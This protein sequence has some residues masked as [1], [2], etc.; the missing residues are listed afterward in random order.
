MRGVGVRAQAG[1]IGLVR[2]GEDER[3]IRGHGGDPPLVL[4]TRT[5]DLCRGTRLMEPALLLWLVW[6]L[7]LQ[8]EHIE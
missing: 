8:Y 2:G 4:P 6:S 3:I 5:D 7:R 1:R